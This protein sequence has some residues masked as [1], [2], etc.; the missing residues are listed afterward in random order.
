MITVLT[1]GNIKSLDSDII[2]KIISLMPYERRE[3]AFNMRE[4]PQ[5]ENAACYGLLLYGLKNLYS[6]SGKIEFS[7]GEYEKPY[8]KD[9]PFFNFSH[10]ENSAV[11]AFSDFEV[12]VDIQQPSTPSNGVIKRVCTE[13]EQEML[14][15]HGEFSRLW[16]QKE[17]ILKYR[18]VGISGMK[19]LPDLSTYDKNSTAYNICDFFLNTFCINGNSV[20]VCGEESEVRIREIQ[21]CEFLDFIK[22]V[23]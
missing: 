23:D 11:C 15:L 21:V 12:G 16:T 3:R 20:S 9:G 8:I 18:G 4:M 2:L 1:L 6:Y 10:C 7:Y 19:E 22:T 17:S 14:T 13:N 5:K